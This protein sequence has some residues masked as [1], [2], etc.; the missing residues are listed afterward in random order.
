MHVCMKPIITYSLRQALNDLEGDCVS[1][2]AK[3]VCHLQGKEMTS[4]CRIP[5]RCIL[6]RGDWVFCCTPQ[7]SPQTWPLEEQSNINVGSKMCVSETQQLVNSNGEH[8]WPRESKNQNFSGRVTSIDWRIQLPSKVPSPVS[9]SGY[10]RWQYRKYLPYSK[11][12]KPW[13]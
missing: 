6:A 3:N 7:E 13:W 5:T 1:H 2:K 9:T 4:S 11:D 10:W 8:R 12:W